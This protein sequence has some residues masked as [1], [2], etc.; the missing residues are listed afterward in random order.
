VPDYDEQLVE[1]HQLIP[2]EDGWSLTCYQTP[3][4]LFIPGGNSRMAH[5]LGQILSREESVWLKWDVDSSEVVEW[6]RE[7]WPF[8]LGKID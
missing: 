6:R 8:D 4:P 3:Q 5:E 2:Q 7:E 1:L